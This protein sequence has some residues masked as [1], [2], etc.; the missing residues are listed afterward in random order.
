M[1]QELRTLADIVVNDVRGSLQFS[2]VFFK[3][4]NL[5]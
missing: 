1:A 3:H 2:S 4:F 5:N